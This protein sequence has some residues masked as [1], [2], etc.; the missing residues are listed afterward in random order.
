LEDNEGEKLTIAQVLVI[1]QLKSAL[2]ALIGKNTL[3]H[4]IS[5]VKCKSRGVNEPSQIIR[6]VLCIIQGRPIRK[7][8]TVWKK[9]FFSL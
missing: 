3:P 4:V 9:V 8:S 1:L 7:Q 5:L 2:N 6:R